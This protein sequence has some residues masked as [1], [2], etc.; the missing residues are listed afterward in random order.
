MLLASSSNRFEAQETN[1]TGRIATT[2][3]TQL[4]N[5]TNTYP[6]YT[7]IFGNTARDTYAIDL[8]F[9][10]NGVSTQARDTI[11]TIGIDHSGA[12][13][14]TDV[15]IQ[16]LLASCAGAVGVG[17]IVYRFPLFIPAGSAIAAKASTNNA[18]PGQMRVGIRCWQKPSRPDLVRTAAYVDTFGAVTASS[19][20]TTITPGTV[21]EGTWT[22][23]A[24]NLTS[25]RRYW[26]W[27]GGVG[28]NN[29]T[30]TGNLAYATDF[31]IGTSNTVVDAIYEDEDWYV[32]N[33]SETLCVN[34]FGDHRY[35]REITGD[36]ALDVW[37][38]MQ[39]TAAADS[40]ISAA[41]YGCGG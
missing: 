19:R 13:T 31:G 7:K 35:V 37:C 9:H 30:M 10:Q 1:L 21:A 20:G 41:L 18:T 12:T 33:T 38:R 29:A 25:G 8:F 6:A 2:W 32:P 5:G 4:T 24:T 28:C 3:G 39:V 34:R 17:P 40:G 26:W 14:Y 36:G 23:L 16:H 15:E 27:Q 22:S 11:V